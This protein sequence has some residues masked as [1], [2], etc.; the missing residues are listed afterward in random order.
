MIGASRHHISVGGAA[1][2]GLLNGLVSYWKLDEA[3]GT[4]YD[5]HGSN[6][7]TT[8]IGITYGT[9]GKIDD[10]ITSTSGDYVSMGDVL[11]F[12]YNEPFTFSAWLKQASDATGF[13]VWCSKYQRLP[14]RGYVFGR[15]NNNFTFNLRQNDS[16]NRLDMTSSLSGAAAD[17]WYH[18]VITYDGS[19]DPT[20]VKF[21]KNGVVDTSP[22][23]N[24]D[25]LTTTTTNTGAFNISS[26]QNGN[27]SWVGDI[28]ELGVWNVELSS[29]DVSDLYNSG[30]G[31]SYDNFTS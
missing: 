13:Q 6:D 23:T 28:D 19:A 2:N 7:S 24:Y 22:T 27:S 9:T 11:D 25:T 8:E 30:S 3:S 17:G 29:S 15:F 10:S 12:D 26:R 20:G 5:S 1:G 14:N 4:L 21:Y 18:L 16:F 31:L